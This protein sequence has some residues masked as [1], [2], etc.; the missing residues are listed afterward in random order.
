MVSPARLFCIAASRSL[1]STLWFRVFINRNGCAR[2]AA[3]RDTETK[4]DVANRRFIADVPGSR[5][6]R[7][8][9][10]TKRWSARARAPFELYAQQPGLCARRKRIFGIRRLPPSTVAQP[11]GGYCTVHATCLSVLSI[12]CCLSHV[13]CRRPP[14]RLTVSARTS[15]LATASS[16]PL[17]RGDHTLGTSCTLGSLVGASSST[18]A[19]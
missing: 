2:M 3:L 11:V 5:M 9:E 15:A 1:P 18:D 19:C 13:G 6:P 17:S 12:V 4:P 7:S 8:G 14:W 10:G 16:A